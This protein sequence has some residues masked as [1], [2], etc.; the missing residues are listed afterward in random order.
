MK[1][2]EIKNGCIFYYSNPAGYVDKDAIVMD[3][4]FRNEELE[5]WIANRGFG[6]R[7]MDGVYDRLAGAGPMK[8]GEMPAP[9]KSCRIWQLKP[10]VDAMMKFIS[11]EEM[12][13]QFGEP[14]PESYELAYEG[15]IESND[16][17][18]IWGI[19]NERLPPGFTGHSLSMSDVVELY[20]QT[21]SEFHYVDRAGYRQISFDSRG[22]EQSCCMTM[23]M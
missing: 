18:E 3:N 9:L 21:G 6:A 1:G 19:F 15:Q 14:S 5:G 4:L 23:R 10:D 8:A 16:L 12:T 20:D 13:R 2:I 22:S 17:D 7:W 11:Y